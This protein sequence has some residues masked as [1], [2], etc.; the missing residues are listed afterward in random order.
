M[1]DPQHPPG[2]Y[3]PGQTKEVLPNVFVEKGTK[4]YCGGS[5][6]GKMQQI[7]FNF[8]SVYANANINVNKSVDLLKSIT[9]PDSQLYFPIFFGFLVNQAQI[10]ANVIEFGGI[11]SAASVWFPANGWVLDK[12]I[13]YGVVGSNG[14]KRCYYHFAVEVQFR[15]TVSGVSTVV[16]DTWT[17]FIDEKAEKFFQLKEWLDGRVSRIQPRRTVNGDVILTLDTNNT[18]LLPW[19]PIGPNV[20]FTNVIV[21]PVTIPPVAPV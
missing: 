2:I 12:E 3:I 11:V 17:I 10:I 7:A 4:L 6:R 18:N 15:Q 19:P 20:T 14:K 16:N 13:K 8:A 21:E 5:L 1:S 9:F